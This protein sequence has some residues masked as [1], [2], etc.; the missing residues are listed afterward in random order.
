MFGGPAEIRVAPREADQP[1]EYIGPFEVV[2]ELA[3]SRWGEVFVCK[4]PTGEMTAVKVFELGHSFSV[5]VTEKSV[6]IWRRRFEQES[7]LLSELH[8]PH[9]VPLVGKGVDKAGRPY[10]AMPYFPAN[11]ITEI[12]GDVGGTA[13]LVRLA[14]IRRPKPIPVPRALTIMRQILRAVAWLHELGIVHRDL[15]PGNILMTRKRGGR[16]RL[17]DFGMAGVNGRSLT[18]PGEK[19][20]SR[21][22]A[23]PDLNEPSSKRGPEVDVYSIG[24]IGYR[25]LTG[26]PACDGEFHPRQ[27]NQDVPDV[28]DRIIARALSTDP[29]ERPFSAA[30]ML[31]EI[32]SAIR[33]GYA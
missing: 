11:L 28:V 25:M 24:A 30:S 23:A 29:A 8:H 20:G 14:P 5:D 2:S 18:I 9:V 16:V 17:A 3:R 12:G 21:G 33:G 10:F 32:E 4:S 26:R 31:G 7:W 13:N 22:Y 6:A 19:L 1:A 15:K 27:R